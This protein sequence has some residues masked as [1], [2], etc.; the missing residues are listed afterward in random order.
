MLNP[1]QVNK[2]CPKCD[3]NYVVSNVDSTGY[4]LFCR[5]CNGQIFINCREY[6]KIKQTTI[7][8]GPEWQKLL[9]SKR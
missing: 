1:L 3:I 2:K 5:K 6:N 4:E 9:E 8:R 7:K